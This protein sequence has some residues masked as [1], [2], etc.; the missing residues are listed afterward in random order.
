[1]YLW[2][3]I[4]NLNF[5]VLVLLN[6]S[7]SFKLLFQYFST[8]SFNLKWLN[9]DNWIN[10]ILFFA[11]FVYLNQQLLLKNFDFLE[12]PDFLLLERQD[13]VLQFKLRP[14]ETLAK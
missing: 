10:F 4:N 5:A 6:F 3:S 8:G 7:V 12:K 2:L 13:S 1:M 9:F 11:Y 14:L